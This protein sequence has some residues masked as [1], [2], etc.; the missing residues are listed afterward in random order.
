MG[1]VDVLKL[2]YA[3]L[4]QINSMSSG[5]SADSEGPAWNKFWLSLDDN[6]ESESMV[7]GGESS[8]MPHTPDAR[9]LMS[10]EHMRPDLIGRVDSVMPGE[11]ASHHGDDSEDMS[12]AA[13]VPVIPTME[14]APFAFKFKAPSGRVHR[15][16]VVPSAGMEQ[17]VTD[18]SAKLGAD[19]DAIGGAPIVEDGKLGKT[20]FALSYLDNEGDTVSIT[21]NHVLIEA[22]T[23]ARQNRRDKVDLFVHDP[24]SA[25]LPA[26]VNPHPGPRP[27]PTPADSVVTNRKGRRAMQD[28]DDE[29]EEEEEVEEAKTS[30][31]PV[32]KAAAPQ[33]IGGI[34]NEALLPAAIGVLAIVIVGVF[35]FGRSTAK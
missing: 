4:D 23:L 29:D 8:R 20:G 2:T 22:I 24:E 3:T 27:P 30:K 18:V 19:I 7:S 17:L 1:M 34:P 5:E 10:P 11:S 13:P 26:T 32:T 6:D 21:T 9:S 14:D 35:A 31:K 33:A 25:P 16:Q 15:L 12:V 28:D